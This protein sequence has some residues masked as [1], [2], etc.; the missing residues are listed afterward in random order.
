MSFVRER[1][2][3][4][5]TALVDAGW[6]LRVRTMAGGTVDVACANGAFTRI[7]DVKRSLAAQNPAWPAAR[8]RLVLPLRADHVDAEPCTSAAAASAGAASTSSSDGNV[9]ARL[10][11]LADNCTLAAY[12]LKDGATLE[13]LVADIS[14]NEH[15]LALISTVEKA[16]DRFHMPLGIPCL[17]SEAASAISWSIINKVRA[18]AFSA[19]LH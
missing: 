2:A 11:P 19:R 14:W 9:H 15:Q 17:G 12:R 5:T 7:A 13:L 4:A 18:G 6:T 1:S 16:G 8:L 3:I 10:E